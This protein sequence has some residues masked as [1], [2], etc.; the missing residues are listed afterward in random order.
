MD[1]AI[2]AAVVA[3]RPC[4]EGHLIRTCINPQSLASLAELGTVIYT[5]NIQ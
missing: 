5:K 2:A 4:V 3:L 1:P